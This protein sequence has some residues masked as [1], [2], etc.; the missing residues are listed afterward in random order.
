MKWCRCPQKLHYIVFFFIL[1][2]SCSLLFQV[3]KLTYFETF[4]LVTFKYLLFTFQP[5]SG[6]GLPPRFFFCTRFFFVLRF[7]QSSH[8]C[9]FVFVC[10]FFTQRVFDFCQFFLRE[11]SIFWP[12]IFPATKFFVGFF[13]VGQEVAHF[14]IS[15]FPGP[16]QGT[17]K[18]V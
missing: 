15:M 9:V 8:L 4:F 3:A 13:F 17:S 7:W 2:S 18:Q 12:R 1:N 5:I 10:I 11:K 14:G 16:N 6:G